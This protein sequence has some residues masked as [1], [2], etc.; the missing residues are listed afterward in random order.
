[1]GNEKKIMEVPWSGDAC[2]ICLKRGEL[3]LEHV[4]PKA[5]HGDLASRFLC[6]EC[7]SFF[8]HTIDVEAK[9]DPAIRTAAS[10]LVKS[11]PSLVADIEEGQCYLIHTDVAMLHGLRRGSEIR[12]TWHT[13]PDGSKIAPEEKAIESLRGRMRA[14][15]LSEDAI[16]EAIACYMAAESG[17]IVDLSP[18]WMAKKLAAYLA[19]PDLRSP[20]A[21]PLLFVKIAY[22]FAA[23]LVGRAIYTRSPQLD[24]R[25]GSVYL[26][27]SSR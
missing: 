20:S 17:K 22:E 1:M 11:V 7:N 23:L 4:I 18:T 8:G 14:E 13:M 2:I 21:D 25:G 24:V 12:G 19:G 15:N 26:N 9:S 10:A 27:S 5:L 6:R 3:S 16:E